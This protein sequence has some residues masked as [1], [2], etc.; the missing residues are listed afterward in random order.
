MLGLGEVQASLKNLKS[1]QYLDA[2][3]T[4]ITVYTSNSQGIFVIERI[5]WIHG[6]DTSFL[7][8]FQRLNL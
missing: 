6:F 2:S 8:Q 1:L 5:S 3:L 4:G 7:L